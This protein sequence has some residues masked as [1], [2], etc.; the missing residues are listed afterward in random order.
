[1][2]STK[3]HYASKHGEDQTKHKSDIST[4][5]TPKTNG[6]YASKLNIKRKKEDYQVKKQ[7]KKT[8]NFTLLDSELLASESRNR[9]KTT[10]FALQSASFATTKAELKGTKLGKL[11][12]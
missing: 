7:G 4:P 3:R 11:S 5:V 1:M 8:S 10:P 2:Q 6:E 12:V 9:T